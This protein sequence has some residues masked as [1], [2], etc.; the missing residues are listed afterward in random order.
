M[1]GGGEKATSRGKCVPNSQLAL[2]I[3]P[4]CACA[5]LEVL[6]L[7]RR[8]KENERTVIDLDAIHCLLLRDLLLG[9]IKR[10]DVCLPDLLRGVLTGNST[11]PLVPEFAAL[12]VGRVFFSTRAFLRNFSF[13]I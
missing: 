4:A 1:P 11:S 7:T 8:L 10:G 6:L 9:S 13:Q 3:L 2:C 12:R 5:G